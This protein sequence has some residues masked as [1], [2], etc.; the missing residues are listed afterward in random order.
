MRH[1]IRFHDATCVVL[2]SQRVRGRRNVTPDISHLRWLPVHGL[3]VFVDKSVAVPMRCAAQLA[4]APV[5]RLEAGEKP[6]ALDLRIPPDRL[7][8][9]QVA[10]DGADRVPFGYE[11]RPAAD[12]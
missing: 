12:E 3:L 1:D 10:A 4:P 9:L 8:P 5:R 7:E 11:C 6:V 2:F